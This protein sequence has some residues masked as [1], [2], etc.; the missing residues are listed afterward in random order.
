MRKKRSPIFRRTACNHGHPLV[1]VDV[2]IKEKRKT[3][4]ANLRPCRGL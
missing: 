4:L 3:A 2:K 1:K